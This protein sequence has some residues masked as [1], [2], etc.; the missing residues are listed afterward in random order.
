MNIKYT[1]A[2]MLLTCS[3]QSFAES[4]SYPTEDQPL[5]S[6]KT[7]IGQPFQYPNGSAIITSALIEMIP[8]ESTGW[9]HHEAPVF[10]MVLEGEL[11]VDYGENGKRV[12]RKSDRFVEAFR[13]SHNGTN[14]GSDP[15][16]ILAGVAG[17]DSAENT[18]KGLQQV[19]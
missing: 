14:T 5:V 15:V 6:A 19:P 16:R 3:S 17:S 10:A 2:C 9:H 12:Y 1:L 8:G 18:V 4:V 13:T 7:I 11:T